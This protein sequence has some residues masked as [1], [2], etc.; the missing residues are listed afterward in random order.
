M[1]GAYD[2]NAI[3]VAPPG[4]CV[5]V[6][7][8]P[9]VRGSWE[10]QGIDGWYLGHAL[11]HYRGF[12][13]FENNTAHSRIADTVENFPHNFNNTFQSSSDNAIEAEKQLAHALQNPA[14]SAPF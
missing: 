7:E 13:V 9:E 8:K 6:H 2:F 12:E 5:V 14:P 3:P 10:I 4:T 11:Y 1:Y